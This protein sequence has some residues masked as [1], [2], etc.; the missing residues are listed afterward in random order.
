MSAIF[1]VNHKNCF[2]VARYQKPSQHPILWA[3]ARVYIFLLCSVCLILED[4]AYM[5]L[6]SLVCQKERRPKPPFK[7]ELLNYF[8]KPS[9]L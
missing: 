2:G 5:Q 4:I 7:A 1:I 8:F 9:T 3:L 6:R